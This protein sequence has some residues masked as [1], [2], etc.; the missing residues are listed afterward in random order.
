MPKCLFAFVLVVFSAPAVIAQ[1]S[2]SGAVKGYVYEEGTLTPI[3]G[4]KVSVRHN[5][6]GF[7]RPA[8]TD[9]S[10]RYFIDMLRVGDY[11]ITGEHPNYQS[12]PSS[13]GPVQV[14]INW[15]QEVNPPPIELRRIGAA[16][17]V[18]T[19]PP[20]TG[21]PP[22]TAL[23]NSELLVNTTNASRGQN[24]DRRLILSLPLSGIRTFDDLA[25]LAPGVF[26]PPRAIGRLV[27]TATASR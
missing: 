12:V 17:V 13:M 8:T 9:A 25:F 10:G 22:S 16:P 18:T 5:E 21:T 24:F 20:V 2:I 3:S 19:P 6:S 23:N 27:A 4:A 11:T 26:P 15:M 1:T 7:V 14:R